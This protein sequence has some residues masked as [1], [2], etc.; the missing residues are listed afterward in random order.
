MGTLAF[1]IWNLSA[2]LKRNGWNR[3]LTRRWL[4][5]LDA[6]RAP[7]VPP[8][9]IISVT[10]SHDTVT[11]EASARRQLDA[12]QVPE[13]NRFSYRRG[14]FTIPLGM[15]RDQAPLRRLRDVLDQCR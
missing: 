13:R 8:E 6:P 5:R 14:H 12:W 7:C 10:G 4:L 2:I 1:Y 9:C 11:P 3:E 15:I